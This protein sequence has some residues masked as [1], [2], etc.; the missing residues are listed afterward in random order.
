MG[1]P[2]TGID[3]AGIE[4]LAPSLLADSVRQNRFA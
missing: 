1:N 2:R 3:H 4:I